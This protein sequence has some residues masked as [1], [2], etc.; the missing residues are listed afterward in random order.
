METYKNNSDKLTI[1]GVNWSED[2]PDVKA[3][4]TEFK[5]PFPIVVDRTGDI[6]TLLRAPTHPHSV[7]INKYG[8]ITGIVPG[9][10]SPEMMK[11][12]L[13]KIL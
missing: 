1:I 9:M 2:D 8:V 4:M 3:F 6:I 5:I 13:A 7:F 10:V 12:L 11:D